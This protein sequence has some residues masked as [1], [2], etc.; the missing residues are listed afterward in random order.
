MPEAETGEVF[1]IKTSDRDTGIKTLLNQFNLQDYADKKMALKAN[2]N[3]SDPFPALTGF[4]NIL[5]LG[6]T[7]FSLCTNGLWLKQ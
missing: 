2:F 3:S 5:K 4:C 6:F 7:I 1:L